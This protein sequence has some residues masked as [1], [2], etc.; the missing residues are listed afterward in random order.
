MTEPYV[1]NIPIIGKL[2][3]ILDWSLVVN[4]LLIGIALGLAFYGW[5]LGE[6]IRELETKLADIEREKK[7][8]ATSAVTQQNTPSPLAPLSDDKRIPAVR[9]NARK[10][11]TEHPTSQTSR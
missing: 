4:V 1:V 9:C 8:L 6:R 2:A 10:N 11:H 7:T 3:A 5:R